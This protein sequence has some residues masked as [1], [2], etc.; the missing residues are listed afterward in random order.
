MLVIVDFS[1]LTIEGLDV[2]GGRTSLLSLVV[3][4]C[5]CQPTGPSEINQSQALAIAEEHLRREHAGVERM[6][7]TPIIRESGDLWV[8]EYRL[9][10]GWSGGAPTV[11][12]RKKDGSV[13]RWWS[14]Q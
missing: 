11:E 6:P 8:V 3:L 2:S 7:V 9:A 4:A 14:D 5:A 12:I 1:S 13:V 10:E